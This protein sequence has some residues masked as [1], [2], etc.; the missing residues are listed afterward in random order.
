MKVCSTYTN[1]RQGYTLGG[2][3]LEVA[4]EKVTLQAKES[5]IVARHFALSASPMFLY[6]FRRNEQRVPLNGAPP[7]A[8]LNHNTTKY[9]SIP[10]Q[11][12]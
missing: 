1:R 2:S 4:L 5:I 3:E 11:S 8:L 9:S 6:A 12:D 7:I 10:I